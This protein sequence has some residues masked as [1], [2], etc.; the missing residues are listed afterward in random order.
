MIFT[1][2]ALYKRPLN[3]W[4]YPNNID[5]NAIRYIHVVWDNAVF[6]NNK[7]IDVYIQEVRCS[8]NELSVVL[9]TADGVPLA[10]CRTSEINAIVPMTIHDDL[11]AFAYVCTGALL[12]DCSFVFEKGKMPRMMGDGISFT[13]S[14]PGNYMRLNETLIPLDTDIDI[15]LDDLYFT[16]TVNEDNEL[17]VNWTDAG[18]ALINQDPTYIDTVDCVTT[19]NNIA[20]DEDGNINIDIVSIV[21]NAKRTPLTN[22]VSDDDINT[23]VACINIPPSFIAMCALEEPAYV[24]NAF[25]DQVVSKIFSAYIGTNEQTGDTEFRL[26]EA[27]SALYETVMTGGIPLY[28]TN[29]ECDALDAIAHEL[30]CA[31]GTE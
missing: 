23:R 8:N 30:T 10:S 6:K 25:N 28:T 12:E 18:D 20:P 26:E 15:Q 11:C 24:A 4:V 16:G 2:D 29:P 5:A 22:N 13:A 19:V 31:E 27:E 9:V 3:L 17:I 14:I 21:N 7:N 1:S